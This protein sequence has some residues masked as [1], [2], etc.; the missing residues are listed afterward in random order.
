MEVD[1]LFSVLVTTS[2]AGGCTLIGAFVFYLITKKIKLSTNSKKFIVALGGG[3]LVSAITLV[4]VPE[5]AKHLSFLQASC[6]LLSGSIVFLLLDILIL[7]CGESA[8]QVLANVLDSFPES[9]GIGA[10]LGGSIGILLIILVGLQNITEGFNSFDELRSAGTST[11][12]NFFLQLLSSLSAPLGG[13]VG[14]FFLA[15]H[16]TMIS[17]VFMFSAGGILY[18]IFHD[19]APLAHRDSHWLPTLGASVGF[20]V[21]LAAQ[22]L[23]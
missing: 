1:S 23:V 21:G 8:S 6:W 14:F 22:Y 11:G 2:I 17:A 13:I 15:G 10:A 12:K 7:Y 16:L 4:L 19:I 9:I 3:I 20:A 18:L 5:G